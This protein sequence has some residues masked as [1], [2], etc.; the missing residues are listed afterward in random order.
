MINFM[1][2]YEALQKVCLL[3]D[4]L[5][6]LPENVDIVTA[7]VSSLMCENGVN[8]HIRS[9]IESISCATGIDIT[10]D[11]VFNSYILRYVHSDVCDYFQADDA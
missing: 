3:F 4:V 1:T 10:G 5:E 8:M 6:K 11:G 7:S 9:G 2:K